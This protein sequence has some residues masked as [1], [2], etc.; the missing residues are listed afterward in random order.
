MPF[1][2]TNNNELK[3]MHRVVS[4][5]RKNAEITG[6]AVVRSR[7]FDPLDSKCEPRWWK[8]WQGKGAIEVTTAPDLQ[9]TLD[10]IT[11]ED[12]PTNLI[13]VA[14]R[15]IRNLGFDVDSSDSNLESLKILCA[16]PRSKQASDSKRNSMQHQKA[17]LFL[18]GAS[19]FGGVR[20]DQ[21][22]MAHGQHKVYLG[23][24]VKIRPELDMLEKSLR[25]AWNQR[26]NGMREHFNT[27]RNTNM[28][29]EWWKEWRGPVAGLLGACVTTTKLGVAFSTTTITVSGSYGFGLLAGSASYSTTTA[30]A[31]AAG[32]ALLLG[33]A[34]AAMVY[35]VPW[36]DLLGC[37]QSCF[38]S[39]WDWLMDLISGIRER[40][41]QWSSAQRTRYSSSGR[42][43]REEAPPPYEHHRHGQKL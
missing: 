16:S 1:L 20:L 25:T 8:F 26:A 15:Y 39:F 9:Y 5:E 13:I 35:F 43:R 18:D 14:S 23:E 17:E 31:T 22:G 6:V 11:M 7:T 2:P 36:E 24:N 41:V 27:M 34:T 40:F 4:A 3:D 32:P 28:L 19:T 29:G 38:G 10:R 30:V 12:R 33:A 42:G 37:F 21:W